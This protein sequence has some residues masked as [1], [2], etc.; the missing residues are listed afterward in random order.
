MNPPLATEWPFPEVR[1]SLAEARARASSDLQEL[2]SRSALQAPPLPST[3]RLWGSSWP[4]PQCCPEARYSISPPTET[5]V[6]P[7]LL[8][9][10]TAARRRRPSRCPRR[11]SSVLSRPSPGC[12]CSPS[13][14]SR[15]G[16]RGGGADTPAADWPLSAPPRT[17]AGSSLLR[18]NSHAS[19]A[20]AQGGGGEEEEEEEHREREGRCLG[21]VLNVLIHPQHYHRTSSDILLS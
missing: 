4:P 1:L 6:A 21:M 15:P 19:E 17:S 18:T 2:H 9:T 14:P 7:F 5:R 13:P 10:L 20:T 11:G 16:G 12:C 3:G 8:A